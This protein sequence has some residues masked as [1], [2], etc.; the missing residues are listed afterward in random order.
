MA[1]IKLR[2]IY[3]KWYVARVFSIALTFDIINPK[4]SVTAQPII[5]FVKKTS[6]SMMR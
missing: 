5:D 4:K 1:S 6:A 2:Q 3:V